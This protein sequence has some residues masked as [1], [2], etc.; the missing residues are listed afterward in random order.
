MERLSESANYRPADSARLLPAS[1][2]SDHPSHSSATKEAAPRSVPPAE[3]TSPP[4]PQPSG[5]SSSSSGG[6]GANEQKPCASQQYYY[7]YT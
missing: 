6:G 7:S 5:E 1:L 4:P 2:R 3:K